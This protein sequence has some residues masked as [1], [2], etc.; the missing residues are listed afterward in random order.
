MSIY[1]FVMSSASSFCLSFAQI[2][3]SIVKNN[4]NVYIFVKKR[5]R[6][7][8]SRSEIIFELA[9]AHDYLHNI[10]FYLSNSQEV[11]V[12]KY[13]RMSIICFHYIFLILTILFLLMILTVSV[14]VL[15]LF[16]LFSV[17]IF[18]S[19]VESPLSF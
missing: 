2:S 9:F 4:Y 13:F 17:D 18:L 8:Y 1:L 7:I 15:I 16:F 11:F 14:S 10:L 6:N 5:L 12:L 19:S 3:C